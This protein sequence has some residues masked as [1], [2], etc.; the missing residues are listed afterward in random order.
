MP[1]KCENCLIQKEQRCKPV[2]KTL[3][4]CLKT[5]NQ[6]VEPDI[7]LPALKAL[8][9]DGAKPSQQFTNAND[10]LPP[11]ISEMLVQYDDFKFRVQNFVA[12]EDSRH[13]TV[14]FLVNFKNGGEVIFRP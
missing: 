11:S 4:Q 7:S 13:Q 1:P 5:V 9:G 3:G 12:L 8:V 6:H 2:K 10:D 14:G